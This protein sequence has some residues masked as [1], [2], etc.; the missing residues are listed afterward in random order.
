[1]YRSFRA[2]KPLE[3]KETQNP[4]EAGEPTARSVVSAP[5]RR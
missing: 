5:K 3:E 1:M 2:I 4:K